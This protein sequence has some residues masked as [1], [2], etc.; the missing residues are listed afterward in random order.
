M[1]GYPNLYVSDAKTIMLA[2]RDSVRLKLIIM[3][4]KTGI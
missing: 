1:H 2:C 3:Y 4:L